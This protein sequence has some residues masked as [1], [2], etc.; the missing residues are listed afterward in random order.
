MDKKKEFLTTD[1]DDFVSFLKKDSLRLIS[2]FNGIKYGKEL[3][4]IKLRSRPIY[5][6]KCFENLKEDLRKAEAELMFKVYDLR[7]KNSCIVTKIENEH[8]E[9]DGIGVVFYIIVTVLHIPIPKNEE[10]LQELYK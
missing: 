9:V 7:Q 2:K 1:T 6:S 10:T 5:I 8:E 4:E 3:D